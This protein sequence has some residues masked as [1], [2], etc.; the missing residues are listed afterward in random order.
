[1]RT[2]YDVFYHDKGLTGQ[3]GYIWLWIRTRSRLNF[4]G[5]GGGPVADWMYLALKEEWTG[6][7]WLWT[8]TSSELDVSG[9]G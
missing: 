2:T 8:G 1:M 7:I 5:D 3:T 6:C 9:S 4:S